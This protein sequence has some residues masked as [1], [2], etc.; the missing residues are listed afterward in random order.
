MLFSR[1]PTLILMECGM[2]LPNEA[3]P[4]LPTNHVFVDL[5]NIRVIDPSVIGGRNLILH[6]FLGPENTKLDVAVVELLLEHSRS[7]NMV[8]SPRKGNNALDFVL[9]YHLGQ[10]VLADPKGYFHIVSKDAGFDALV[11]LLKSKNVRVKRHEDWSGL[12]FTSA[13]KPPCEAA[14]PV[15]PPAPS[16][17]KPKP[18][19]PKPL[20]SGAEKVL[21]NLKKSAKNRPKKK[22]TL[23]NHAKS[24]L[25]KESSGDAADRVVGELQ[26]AGRIKIDDKG[27]VTYKL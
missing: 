7:V 14:R 22:T 10:A 15:V 8:R 24:F 17:I 19:A 27:I 2:V 25:G 16:A 26:K 3:I 4:H 9:S 20:S 21:G 5:E 18:P 1:Q 23:I 12:Q 6:L 11:D 13:P